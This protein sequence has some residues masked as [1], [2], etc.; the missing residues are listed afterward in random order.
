MNEAKKGFDLW[1][2]IL[3]LVCLVGF[4]GGIYLLN[5][6][7]NTRLDAVD[8]TGD[9]NAQT[10]AMAIKRLDNKLAEVLASV[11]ALEAKVAAPPA[12]PPAPPVASDDAA[13]PPPAK[14]E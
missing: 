13:A 3:I 2:M 6:T 12:P 4:I 1:R 7:I 9:G 5:T 14:T 10:T 11:K 8:A